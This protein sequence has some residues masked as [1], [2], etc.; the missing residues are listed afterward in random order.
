ML[1]IYFIMFV[2]GLAGIV[3]SLFSIFK[4]SQPWIR[5]KR[6]SR[7]Q[8][9][10]FSQLETQH[11]QLRQLRYKMPLMKNGYIVNFYEQTLMS[12][13]TLLAAIV[14]IAKGRDDS[15]LA[16]GAGSFSPL[17]SAQ[18]LVSHL[19]GKIK[20]I[21]KAVTT[22][23]QGQPVGIE[24][25][26][27]KTQ[28]SDSLGCYFCSKPEIKSANSIVKVK[29]DGKQVKAHS[30]TKCRSF[31]LTHKTIKVLFFPQDGQ[32][33]HWSQYRD[34]VSNHTYWNLNGPAETKPTKS[35]LRLLRCDN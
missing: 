30:C 10:L 35:Q 20:T 1:V 11:R 25:L 27:P 6:R 9:S 29:I 17:E 3:Y 5:A 2:V 22:E 14:A 16:Q 12:F 19:S 13:E 21:E 34:F 32:N 4:E 28:S 33:V 18:S 31:L 8:G 26:Y 24:D 15:L 7:S 23:L